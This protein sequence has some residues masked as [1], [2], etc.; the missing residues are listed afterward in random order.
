[1]LQQDS[2]SEKNNIKDKCE[3]TKSNFSLICGPA[4]L[5][6][7]WSL[8]PLKN[9]LL[10]RSPPKRNEKMYCPKGTFL[11]SPVYASGVHHSHQV[12]SKFT[13]DITGEYNRSSP[14]QPRLYRGG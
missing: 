11:N 2:L 13:S 5:T 6:K 7:K 4:K 1:M 10:N 14:H 8:D 3:I 12:V 9:Y